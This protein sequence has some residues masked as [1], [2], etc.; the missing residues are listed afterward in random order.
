MKKI[1]ET[2]V[3]CKACG[4]VWHYGKVEEL[5]SAGAALQNVG[6]SMMCCSGCAPAALLPTQTVVDLDKC[7][8]CG[9]RAVTKEVVEHEVP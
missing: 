7:Q 9:S 8:K 6:K 4:N 3:I 1:K 5:E 2:R